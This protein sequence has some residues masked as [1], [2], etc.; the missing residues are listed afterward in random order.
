VEPFQT[1]TIT[2]SSL[3]ESLLLPS[4]PFIMADEEEKDSYNNT[5]D[6]NN[7]NDDNNTEPVRN[8][9]KGTV[10][11]RV[12]Y[13]QNRQDLAEARRLEE[14]KLFQSRTRTRPPTPH[15][16]IPNT[17]GVEGETDVVIVTTIHVPTLVDEFEKDLQ[18]SLTQQKHGVGQSRLVDPDTRTIMVGSSGGGQYRSVE[19]LNGD[20]LGG[21][22]ESKY[23]D[24]MVHQAERRLTSKSLSLE[25]LFQQVDQNLKIAEAHS[26][27]SSSSGS[28]RRRSTSLLALE[29]ELVRAEQQYNRVGRDDFASEPNFDNDQD[30]Q[31][32]EVSAESIERTNAMMAEDDYFLSSANRTN[33]SNSGKERQR[34]HS[35]SAKRGSIVVRSFPVP[36][37]PPRKG[38]SMSD[39]KGG[40]AKVEI[41]HKQASFE[42]PLE[43]TDNGL[44]FT[45]KIAE[46]TMMTSVPPSKLGGVWSGS[47]AG[48]SN[49]GTLNES[50]GSLMLEYKSSRRT[51]LS[52]GMIR[53]CKLEQNL[54]TLGGKIMR[55]G[56]SYIGVGLYHHPTNIH[57]ATKIEKW[58]WSCS[59]RHCFA[60]TRW[61]L[62]SQ[63]SRR[64]DVLLLMS[65]NKLSARVEWNL[66]KAKQ[67]S[68]RLDARPRLSEYRKAHMY[69]QWKSGIW[70]VGVSLVQSLHSQV[71]TVG[72]GWRMFSSRGVQWIFSW[73]RGNATINIPITISKE[74]TKT[75]L[76]HA[77]YLSIVSFL[78]QECIGEV[79]GW[80]GDSIITKVDTDQSLENK[81]IDPTRARRDSEKQK[82]LMAR[83]AQRK[84]KIEQ[85]KDG[86]VI[87]HAV[88][89]VK[90]G[91]KLD[92]TIQLQFWV[93]HSTL[94]LPARPKS[95][96]LG[97]YD[98]GA[99][100]KD[101]K[102][103]SVEEMNSATW[104][105]RQIWGDL[106][107]SDNSSFLL[108]KKQEID[109]VPTLTILY[110]FKG[111]SYRI[112]VKDREELRLPSSQA[113]L[114][115]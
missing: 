70:Q 26:Q 12:E 13:F 81:A 79:W 107:G 38:T 91:D 6:S 114:E 17:D 18:Q 80:V 98:V 46:L 83:Q 60:K 66:R 40:Y 105:W 71:S 7:I 28:S 67:L 86:L 65:N 77:M 112:T 110:T 55:Y 9:R 62:F 35:L 3:I 111:K 84:M 8:H 27:Q 23:I 39:T 20:I 68:V 5:N 54:I 102:T 15:S 95:E 108:C 113:T 72:L 49:I 25:G 93:S 115:S 34:V 64:Q 21:S 109:V 42:V 69:C 97:F 85:E 53:G 104:S 57:N 37:E 89:E 50:S 51:R 90:D 94:T 22:S 101:H 103:S 100:L 32:E 43:V 36:P 59:Y 14:E 24:E 73:N 19:Q 106:I 61:Y 52:M 44:K 87:K 96:L 48:K 29:D 33:S 76:G 1:P 78:I 74:L 41:L 11:E 99:S 2:A 10:Q 92:V 4:A 31:F 88:Y 45:P 58:L 63:L 30:G 16:N 75:S 82:E 47:L 56:G